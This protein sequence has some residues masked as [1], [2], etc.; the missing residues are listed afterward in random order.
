ML[1]SREI[2]KSQQFMLNLKKL[3][4]GMGSLLHT[5]NLAVY[6]HFTVNR[7]QQVQNFLQHF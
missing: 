2:V 3:C 6:S 5:A 4:A 1:Q 7:I